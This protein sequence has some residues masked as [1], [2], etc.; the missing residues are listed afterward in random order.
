MP[1]PS[2]AGPDLATVPGM[3]PEP[4]IA[5]QEMPPPPPSA[6]GPIGIVP[7]PPEVD[8]SAEL[9]PDL[10]AAIEDLPTETDAAALA[11]Q[12]DLLETDS[13]TVY[14]PM[15]SSSEQFPLES[16]A[17]ADITED[18]TETDIPEDVRA[19]VEY[20]PTEAESPD[21]DAPMTAPIEVPPE[22]QALL[23][24]DSDI[25][26]EEMAAGT[27]ADPMAAYLGND[28]TVSMRP[29]RGASAAPSAPEGGTPPPP[30][31]ETA[32]QPE[33]PDEVDPALSG[34]PPEVL[35]A[36]RGIPEDSPDSF[37]LPPSS[38]SQPVPPPPPNPRLQDS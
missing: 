21:P 17:I 3:T 2:D 24:G 12:A 28:P 25:P 32:I 5:P 4:G 14:P 10:L 38:A 1:S 19:A 20:L 33:P 11:D 7:P 22:V 29:R 35:E 13:E 37:D 26:G 23:A 15:G 9:P 30:V 8:E 34:L 18:V 27:V 36:L 6:I 31:P 16:E